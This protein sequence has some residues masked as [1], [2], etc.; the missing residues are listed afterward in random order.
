MMDAAPTPSNI[1]R[2]KFNS[3]DGSTGTLLTV[4][5]GKVWKGKLSLNATGSVAAGGS[6]IASHA[7]IQLSGSGTPTPASGDVL[8][9]VFIAVPAVGAGLNGIAV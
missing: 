8:V 1:L 9:D 4:P 5:A 6:A 2:G 3:V 7:T